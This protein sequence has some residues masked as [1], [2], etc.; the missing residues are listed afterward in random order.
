[1]LFH[2]Q[3]PFPVR[4]PKLAVGL[5]GAVSK[6]VGLPGAAVRCGSTSSWPSRHSAVPQAVGL[7]VAVPQAVG[8]PGAVPQAAGLPRVVPQAAGPA[9]VVSQT[10]GHPFCQERTQLEHYLGWG[11]CSGCP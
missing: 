9:R 5:L 7:P 10:V 6:A 2:K 4:F 11:C 3:F 1:M 8:L